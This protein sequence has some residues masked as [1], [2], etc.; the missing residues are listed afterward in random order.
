MP[1]IHV[2]PLNDLIS[3]GA[4]HPNTADT[5]DYLLTET[6]MLIPSIEKMGQG[7][8]PFGIF[9]KI[10][11]QKIYRHPEPA[12]ALYF[13]SPGP[14]L[15]CP[16]FNSDKCFLWYLFQITFDR[17]LDRLLGLPPAC[18][19]LLAKIA[20]SVKQR[21]RDH[22]HLEIGCGA[23]CISCEYTQATAVSGHS[24]IKPDLH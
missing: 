19:E 4:E 13:I 15:N 12:D 24:R 8:V 22:R 10:R 23:D 16:P 20:F 11:I 21:D 18:I 2:K 17:P 9:R 3:E 14:E 1:F 6:V 7:P 5:E